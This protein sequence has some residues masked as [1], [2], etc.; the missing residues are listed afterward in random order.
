MNSR[1]TK[2][3]SHS[4][5]DSTRRAFSDEVITPGKTTVGD[6]RRW[7]YDAMGANNVGTW[8][9]QDI[10][11]QRK[12]LN[13]STSRGFLAVAPESMVIQ[14]GDV[15]HVDFGVTCMGFS[16][17]WTEVR[18]TSCCPA[19]KTLPLACGTQ[20]RTQISCKRP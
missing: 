1:P 3:S 4:P 17:D 18:P 2:P 12:G 14:P 10:R 9:Q 5:T 11:V 6:I 20:R 16:T 8:F 19:R 7:L 15:I 13:P